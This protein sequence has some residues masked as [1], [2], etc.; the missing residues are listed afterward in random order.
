MYCYGEFWSYNGTIDQN[1]SV[2]KMT[3]MSQQKKHMCG[4]K[5][6]YNVC[7]YN[8][9]QSRSIEMNNNSVFALWLID[10]I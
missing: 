1:V 10:F 9:L 7:G 3:K 5:I 4:A 8:I 6:L 2:K